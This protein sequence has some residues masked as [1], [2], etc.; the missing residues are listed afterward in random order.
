MSSTKDSP[1]IEQILERMTEEVGFVPPTMRYLAD[2][3]PE[4]VAEHARGKGFA[5][6]SDRIPDRYKQLIVI[7]AAA[8]AGSAKCVETQTRIA[9]RKGITPDEIVDALLL[10]RF[11]A[12]SSIFANAGDALKVAY[13]DE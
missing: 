5:F 2:H 12:S 3:R 10:A 7:A 11:A 6:A 8:A 13:G 4:V 1:T 9:V